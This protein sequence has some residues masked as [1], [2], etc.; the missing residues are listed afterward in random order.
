MDNYVYRVGENIYINLTNKCSNNC[1][2]CIRNGREGM[3]D[4]KL[5]LS[6]EPAAADVF[7]QLKLQGD[8]KKFGEIVFCGFGEP[9]YNL[10]TLIEVGRFL[11]GSGYKVRLNTNGHGSRI[12]G[13]NIVPLIK[14]SLTEINVSLNSGDKEKYAAECESIYGL[15]AYDIML[16][17]AK[18]C[19]KEGIR[20]VL[21]VVDIIGEAEILKCQAVAKQNNLPLRVRKF[22]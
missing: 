13:K 1:S 3:N 18:E 11:V 17:F 5:W 7:A 21:S 14:N 10:D 16:Q 8:L 19:K 12:N 15:E 22:E 2:F 4:I 6:K 9:T 20:V